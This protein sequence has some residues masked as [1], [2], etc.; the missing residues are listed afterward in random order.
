V[1]LITRGAASPAAFDEPDDEDDDPD[2][3][4]DDEC[5]RCPFGAE[6][7]A[8]SPPTTPCTTF[9]TPE[10]VLTT[11]PTVPLRPGLPD[12]RLVSGSTSRIASEARSAAAP[13]PTLRPLRAFSRAPRV[14]RCL[15]PLPNDIDV[16][17]YE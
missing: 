9:V 5:D 11:P 7:W 17:P 2:E 3:E 10:T 13:L 12:P 16:L 8:S 6:G 15:D 14:I 1:A 4:D